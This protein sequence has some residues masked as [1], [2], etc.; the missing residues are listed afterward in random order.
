[1]TLVDTGPIVALLDRRDAH[2]VWA[3]EVLAAARRPFLT[4]EAV[5]AEACWLL[6]GHG[7]E[8]V[9][10]LG[11]RGFFDSSFA[12][13][14]EWTSVRSLM[15]R[16]GDVPMSLAD[17]CLVRMAELHPSASVITLDTDFTIY[18]KNGRQTIRAIMP[19]GRPR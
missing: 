10:E 13:R 19:R 18:R 12:L 15:R 1:M 8:L 6:R 2:H 17:A 9:V 16:Y 4:C 14:R 5:I 3:K 7:S 11:E